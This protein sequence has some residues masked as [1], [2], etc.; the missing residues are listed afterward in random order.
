MFGVV[1]SCHCIGCC[2]HFVTVVVPLDFTLLKNYEMH[3]ML[4][5]FTHSFASVSIVSSPLASH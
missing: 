4:N 5:R 3:E 2:C 1:V